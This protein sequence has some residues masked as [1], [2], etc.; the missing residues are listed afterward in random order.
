MFENQHD[1]HSMS[2][3]RL[4]AAGPGGSLG[5]SSW[6]MTTDGKRVF[7]NIINNG[8]EDFKLLPS[9]EVV[10]RGGWVALD[11]ATGNFLWSTANPDNFS[12]NPPVRNDASCFPRQLQFF[13]HDGLDFKRTRFCS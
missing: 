1:R 12:T 10:R 2:C 3:G 13:L 7:T 6:G 4:Q 8:M 5:G 9:T 11:A